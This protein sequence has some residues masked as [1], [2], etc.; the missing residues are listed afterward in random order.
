M[1]RRGRRRKVAWVEARLTQGTARPKADKA[2]VA[3]NAAVNKNEK[4]LRGIPLGGKILSL[5]RF[6]CRGKQRCC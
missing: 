1:L 2:W 6:N 4:S 3:W 5:K